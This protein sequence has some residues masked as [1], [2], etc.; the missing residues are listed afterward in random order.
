M[1]GLFQKPATS[2][3]T[4][5]HVPSTL[6]SSLTASGASGC[7]GVLT[8]WTGTVKTGRSKAA[9]H[10]WVPCLP[11]AVCVCVLLTFGL[12]TFVLLTFVPLSDSVAP[13]L[14]TDSRASSIIP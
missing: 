4:A 12:L 1:L 14:G 7:H 11:V 2:S 10:R 5:A 6:G 13:P 3:Q 8:D 9:S